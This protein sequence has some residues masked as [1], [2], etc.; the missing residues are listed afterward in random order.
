MRRYEI[1]VGHSR[2]DKTGL[3]L[4]APWE[5]EEWTAK[6][7]PQ[8]AT[9]LT[10]RGFWQGITEPTSVI[11]VYHES[12]EYVVTQARHAA[13]HFRQEVVIVWDGEQLHTVNGD[14]GVV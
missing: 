3:G 12:E 14:S 6:A 7:F 1:C 10:G 5:V 13:A 2:P 11:V 4:V 9:L 8:G